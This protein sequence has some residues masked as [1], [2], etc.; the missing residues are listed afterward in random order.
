M[1]FLNHDLCVQEAAFTVAILRL[2]TGF[3][4]M[5]KEQQEERKGRSE[6]NESQQGMMMQVINVFP[7]KSFNLHYLVGDKEFSRIAV[8]IVQS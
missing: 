3:P 8:R 6:P 7:Q 1:A 5:H 4:P 2:A